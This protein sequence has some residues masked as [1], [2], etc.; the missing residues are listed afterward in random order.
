MATRAFGTWPS[1]LGADLVAR[2]SSPRFG[3]ID[4]DGDR[5][6]W[7]ESRAAEGGRIVVVEKGPQGVV[8]VTPSG[9]NARTRVHEY[10][11]GAVWYHGDTTFY[12]EFADSRIYRV[13]GAGRSRDR[14]RRNRPRRTRSATPTAS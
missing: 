10:G 11:G 14:S 12:S 5:I 7:A 8:D 4:A 6:R 1:T 13:D 3:A 9:A 2:T